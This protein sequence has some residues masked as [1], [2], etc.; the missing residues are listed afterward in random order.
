MVPETKI[1]DLDYR[2]ACVRASVH[3]CMLAQSVGL[4]PE[5]GVRAGA[6]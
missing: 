5:G 2:C 1:G 4:V 3:A 6:N